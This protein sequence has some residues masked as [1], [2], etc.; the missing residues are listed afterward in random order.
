MGHWYDFD[1]NPR[2]WQEDGKDTTLRHARKQNLLPSVT[3]I[4]GIL[5]KPALTNWKVDQA[6]MAAL[7]LPKRDDESLDEFMSRAKRDAMVEAAKARDRGSEI[8]DAIEIIFKG[9]F[10]ASHPSDVQDIAT[11]AVKVIRE[12]TGKAHFTA[13]ATVVGD[14]Y[15]GMCDLHNDYFVID[16]KTKDIKDV[17]AKITYPEHAMQLAAYGMALDWPL[18]DKRYLNVFIDRKE[19][20]KVVIHEWEPE[21]IQDA[22]EQFELLVRLWQKQKKYFPQPGSEAA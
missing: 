2:H 18:L 10:P 12:Y 21:Q 5:D 7:T 3:T 19:S 14:G 16:Y 17:K 11:E 6:V 8:H 1:G 20:G 9:Q 22:W 15:A 4:I 13:E